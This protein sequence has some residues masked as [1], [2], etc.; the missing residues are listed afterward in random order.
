[1]G[2]YFDQTFVTN[3]IP[4]TC[5]EWK[6]GVR[7]A[8]SCNVRQKSVGIK[9][10]WVRKVLGITMNDVRKERDVATGGNDAATYKTDTQLAADRKL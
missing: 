1:L 8:T 9:I 7:V 5:A 3:A 4:G 2:F 10:F 6:V